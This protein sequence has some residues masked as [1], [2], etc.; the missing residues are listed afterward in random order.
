MP[1]CVVIR[2]FGIQQAQDAEMVL[3]I[4]R[5][6]ASRREEPLAQFQALKDFYGIQHQTRET[7]LKE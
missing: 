1:G 4:K 2:R 7:L 3:A 6:G 5:D